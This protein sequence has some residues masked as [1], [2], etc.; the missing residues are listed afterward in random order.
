ML[1]RL[2]ITGLALA[3]APLAIAQ[4]A[5]VEPSEPVEIEPIQIIRA[6]TMDDLRFL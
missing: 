2:V 4:E 1:T 6:V 5:P 3:M